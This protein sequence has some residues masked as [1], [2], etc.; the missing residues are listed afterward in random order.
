MTTGRPTTAISTRDASELIRRTSSGS[1]PPPPPRVLAERAA[2]VVLAEVGPERVREHELGV[3]GLPEEEV[4]ESL[5]A[6]GADH[7][8]GIGELGREEALGEGRLGDV[9]DR[10]AVLDEASGRLDELSAA[11]VVERDPQQQLVVPGGLSLERGHL[12]AQHLRNP[13][14]APNK[15]GSYSLS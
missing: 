6:R 7:E 9:L 4:R 8:V 11:A 14:A 12:R 15:T 5:L 10:D 1:E 3:R 2:Q 13:V